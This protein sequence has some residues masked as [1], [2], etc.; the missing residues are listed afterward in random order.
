MTI[1]LLLAEDQALVRDALAMLLDMQEDFHVV[2]LVGT[3]NAA[4][5]TVTHSDNIDVA[6]LDVEMPDGDGIET[7]QRIT[8]LKPNV[9][10][11]MLTTFG[12]PGYVQRAFEAGASG[13]ILKDA[14]ANQLAQQIRKIMAGEHVVDAQLAAECLV[15]GGNPL[16][17]R[18]REI[19][20]EAEK[21]GT[22][23]A[24]A[25]NLHSSSGTIRNHISMI[26]AKTGANNRA[27]AVR[28]ARDNGWL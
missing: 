24:M 28:I 21:G 8:A 25:R 13:F 14:P 17:E 6:L 4:V 1:R 5:Q 9:R 2:A 26:I 11:C 7:C 20:I 12:K 23:N 15:L 10:V 18:E 27:D 19:L 16:T 3:G 22:I